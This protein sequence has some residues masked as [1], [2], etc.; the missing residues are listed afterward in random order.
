M[1]L[2]RVMIAVSLS[3][4]LAAG[5]VSSRAAPQAW[6]ELASYPRSDAVPRLAVYGSLATHLPAYRAASTLETFLYGPDAT[7]DLAL[8]NPQ[9]MAA[10]GDRLLVC[11]QGW[12]DVA[13]I[14][15][16]TGKIDSWCDPDHA[17][18]C[19]VDVTTDHAGKVYVA[20]TTR[21]CVL[22]YGANGKFVEQ[23]AP[24]DTAG[25][26]FRPCGL[27]VVD[28]VLCVGNLAGRRLDRFDLAAHQWLASFSPPPERPSCMA[29]TGVCEGPG[30]V[31]LV[32]DAVQ[33]MIHRVT[34]G[35]E[36]LEPLGRPG[37]GPGQF[38]RPKQVCCAPSGLILV[39][40]AG[41]QS[42]VVLD[43]GGHAFAEI[44]EHPGTWD[45]WT[46]PMGLLVLP[47]AAMQVLA[48][49]QVAGQAVLPQVCIVVSDSLGKPSLTL[50]GVV[51]DQATEVADES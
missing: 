19:P 42:V 45:G 14:D 33:G 10:I 5:C 51:G 43:S 6:S 11:D 17:P 25:D 2:T 38:V 1:N 29:P 12:P 13:V 22:V 48:E 15:L 30:G 27:A 21:H 26:Q 16:R 47:P 39:V 18:Q 9:G 28:G 36:W 20:D 40:D 41:R 32:A 23:L 4:L 31:I 8:R 24:G 44:R 37:R 35:G 34:V 46:L 3:G 7:E 49:H 50:L